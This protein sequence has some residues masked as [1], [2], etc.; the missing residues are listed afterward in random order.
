MINLNGQNT[1][2]PG[3]ISAFATYEGDTALKKSQD[4]MNVYVNGD[5]IGDKVLIAQ[6]DGGLNAV[7]NYLLNKGF[8]DFKYKV[9]GN[10]II[11]NAGDDICDE[12]KDHLKVY[13]NIR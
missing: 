3:I 2:A 11:I 7:K 5:F 6:G 13:L 12:I 9:D 8:S 10:N 1:I 4:T